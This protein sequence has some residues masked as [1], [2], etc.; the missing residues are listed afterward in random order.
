VEVHPDK[1]DNDKDRK[2]PND[3]A[4]GAL[5]LVGFCEGLPDEGEFGVGLFGVWLLGFGAHAGF[6][7]TVRYL[8]RVATP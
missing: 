2:H 4:G 5:G 7:S 8:R 3:D 6:L 1:D